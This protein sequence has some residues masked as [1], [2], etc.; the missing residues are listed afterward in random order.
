M[1]A[2]IQTEYGSPD[3][4]HLENVEKPTPKDNEVL[5]KVYA[6]PV[7]FGD[8]TARNFRSISP[9]KFS[10]PFLLWLPSRIIFGIRKPKIKIL[11]S[12]LAGEIEEIGK[13]VKLFKKT[14]QIFAYRAQN[15]G[16]NAEYLCM[17]EDGLIA[18]KPTNMSYEE[19][20]AVPGTALTALNL[21][22]KMDIKPGQKILIIGASGGIGHY[23]VQIAKYFDAEV[24]GIC[25]TSKVEL[26]K[27]LGADKVIDYKNEDFTKNGEK[28][29]IIFDI[30]RNSSFSQSKNSLKQNGK[31]FLVSFKVWNLLQMITTKFIGNKRVICGLSMEKGEDLIF[32]RDL[33]EEG[34]LKSV[35]D[36]TYPLEQISE[37]HEYVENGLKK[38]HVVMTLDHL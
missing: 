38:G 17:S 30:L 36:K 5:V 11:G 8:T 4:L 1:K 26:L 24:T 27:S 3:V 10:M 35:I 12:E 18:L 2:I 34:K 13:D 25:S 31:Y 20:S 29:D 7:T 19:A 28:Y 16:A 14:D 23:A 22:R 15:F 37:A 6:T 32:I 21:L 33:I 9:F